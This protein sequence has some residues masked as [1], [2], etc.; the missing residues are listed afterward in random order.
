MEEEKRN[1][2][3]YYLYSRVGT[4]SIRTKS[5]SRSFFFGSF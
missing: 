2:R 5:V 4:L 1:K 3:G